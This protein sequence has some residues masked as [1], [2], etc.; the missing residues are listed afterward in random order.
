MKEK[1]STEDLNYKFAWMT[2]PNYIKHIKKFSKKKGVNFEVSLK[3]F[4]SILVNN[5]YIL[6]DHPKL[7]S[8]KKQY[9]LFRKHDLTGHNLY[10]VYKE[11][12][13]FRFEIKKNIMN[14]VEDRSSFIEQIAGEVI[15]ERHTGCY[16]TLQLVDM[17]L[18]IGIVQDRNINLYDLDNVRENSDIETIL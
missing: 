14:E 3:W 2:G 8:T 18:Y 10:E 4:L 5:P 13:N 11:Y 16:K 9:K 7:N 12:E 15:G 1:L 6:S 17:L